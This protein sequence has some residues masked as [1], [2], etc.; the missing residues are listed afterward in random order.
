MKLATLRNGSRDGALLIV[1][2]DLAWAIHVGDIT[3][4]LQAALDDWETAAPLLTAR[5]KALADRKSVV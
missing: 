2:R 3:P 1:S 5:A 4:N